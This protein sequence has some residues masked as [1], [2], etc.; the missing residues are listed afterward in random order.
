MVLMYILLAFSEILAGSSPSFPQRWG[1]QGSSS[2]WLFFSPVPNSWDY[3]GSPPK[4]AAC[5]QDP[6]WGSPFQ[7][8]CRPKWARKQFQDR[9]WKWDHWSVGIWDSTA[10]GKR[11]GLLTSSI[12][13]VTRFSLRRQWPERLMQHLWHLHNMET[14]VFIRIVGLVDFSQLL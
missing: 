12:T 8:K 14:M 5:I 3:L 7:G 4:L 10:Y 2:F 9:F 6:A 11:G 13:T 1:P